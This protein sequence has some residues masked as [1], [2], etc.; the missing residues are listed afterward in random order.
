MRY[1]HIGKTF[2]FENLCKKYY[3]SKRN[4]QYRFIQFGNENR[5]KQ[6]I[7]SK[8]SPFNIKRSRLVHHQKLETKFKFK[9]KL[10]LKFNSNYS[11]QIIQLKL[12]KSN[13]SN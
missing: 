10:K 3:R 6:Q 1:V 5:N 13:Y 8:L 11:I 4:Y 9:F 2:L 7:P 12:F